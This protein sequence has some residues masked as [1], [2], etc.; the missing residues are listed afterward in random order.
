MRH[1]RCWLGWVQ[2]RVE[3]L[4]SCLFAAW[5]EVP[6]AVP[7]LADIAVPSR[8]SSRH[9]SSHVQTASKGHMQRPSPQREGADR[10]DCL[11]DRSSGARE[12]VRVDVSVLTDSRLW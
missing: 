12:Y 4:S 10:C 2:V 8:S 7:R 1:S 9:E 5:D 3:A 11:A 6:V